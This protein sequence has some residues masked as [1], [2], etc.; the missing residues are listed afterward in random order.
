M[1]IYIKLLFILAITTSNQVVS[2]VSATGQHDVDVLYWHEAKNGK[3]SY[4]YHVLNKS[5]TSEIVSFMVGYDWRVGEPKL[6]APRADTRHIP[7][8]FHSPTGWS[9]KV[10]YL[11]ESL[12][13][14]LLWESNQPQN[15]IKEGE[16]SYRFGVELSNRRNDHLNTVITVIFGDTTITSKKMAGSESQPPPSNHILAPIY[17]LLLSKG[18]TPKFLQINSAS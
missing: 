8:E 14:N 17:L 5:R 10:E 12:F 11:E 13:Y 6:Y 3:H 18:I 1:K 9:G 16:S 7:L 2:A 15:D 4:F